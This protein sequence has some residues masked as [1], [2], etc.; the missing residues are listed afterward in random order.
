MLA[1]IKIGKDYYVCEVVIKQVAER[2]GFYLLEVEL[3]KKFADVFKT[4]N[5]S[6]PANSKLV[7]AQKIAEVNGQSEDA[8]EQRSFVSMKGE[9]VGEYLDADLFEGTGE[10]ASAHGW[11]NYLLKDRKTKLD[12]LTDG[13]GKDIILIKKRVGATYC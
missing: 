4:V 5:D 9:L 1:P 3:S 13:T 7:I 11:G 10:N 12:T 6:T 8:F 2:Q